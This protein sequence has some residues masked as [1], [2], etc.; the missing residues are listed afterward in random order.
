MC[1]VCSP[2]ENEPYQ[3]VLPR[4]LT[5]ADAN[6]LKVVFLRIGNPI[7]SQKMFTGLYSAF[8]RQTAEDFAHGTMQIWLQV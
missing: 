5:V 8:G 7:S 4:I 2:W 3:I 1:A 6:L